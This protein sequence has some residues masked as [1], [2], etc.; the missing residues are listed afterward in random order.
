MSERSAIKDKRRWIIKVGSALLTNDGKGLHIPAITELAEQIAFLRDKGIDVILVS[1]GSVAAGVTQL[2]MKARP[3]KVNE[4]QAAAAVGQ[5]SLVRHYED[6]FQ[7][8]RINIAQ[9]LL[10][11]SDI[12]NRERY[13]NAR[14]TLIKLLE[15]EVLTVINE[16]DTVATDE[17]CFGDNDSLGAL[18][19][20]LVEAD[21]LV[22]LTDQNGLYTADPR[23]NP[24][25]ELLFEAQA[26][27]ESLMAMAS[28]GSKLGRGGMLTKLSAAQK[29]SRSG[30]STVIANGREERVLERLYAGEL[31]G[32]YLHASERVASR[33][34]WMAGQ[35]KISGTLHLDAGASKVL[36][37]AGKSLLPVGVT[38]I[39]G[40]FKRGELVSCVDPEG[41]EVGRG[42]VNY[43]ADEASKIIGKPSE[44]ITEILAYGGP[45]E[46]IHRDNLVVHR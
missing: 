10:T 22:I 11:H 43:H 45:D 42:L 40:Q 30:A 31:L 23:S 6:A 46:L 9:V 5:A 26:D 41:N 14:S 21:L 4:L 29:A 12:A 1:S 38:S 16:N 28:G 32:T 27:D 34:Q 18:V 13:L 24:D 33:K 36:K 44:Q 8:Y 3:V 2:G 39:D 19:A 15:L 25:A 35:M 20:N 17:I 7:P 37:E